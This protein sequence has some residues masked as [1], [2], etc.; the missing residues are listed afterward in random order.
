[1]QLNLL[2]LPD[3]RRHTDFFYL[4]RLSGLASSPVFLV[5]PIG[6][7]SRFMPLVGF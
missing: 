3:R 5:T 6:A 7:E 4:V 2:D 1:M